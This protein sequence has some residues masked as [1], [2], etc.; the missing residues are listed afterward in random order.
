MSRYYLD[1]LA[2]DP[3]HS[4]QYAR[5]FVNGFESAPED[6]FHIQASSCCKHYVA[7]SMEATR[8]ADG[9]YWNRHNFNANISQQDLVDSYMLPFQICVEQGRVSGLMCSYNAVNNVPSCANKWLLDDVARKEWGFDGK[10]SLNACDCDGTTVHLR[11]V[12]SPCTTGYITSDC[13]AES[14]VVKNHGYADANHAVQDIFGAGTDV[15]CGHFMSNAATAA[16]SGGFITEADIDVRMQNL[17]RVRLRLGHFDPPGPLQAFPLSDVCSKEHVALAMDGLAQS[18]ALIKNLDATVCAAAQC[19]RA[20]YSCTSFFWRWHCLRVLMLG[21]DARVGSAVQIEQ[22]CS[23][24]A[25]RQ[26]VKVNG[27]LLRPA[28]PVRRKLPHFGRRGW[29]VRV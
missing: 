4:G 15:D 11:F 24:W 2:I 27:V 20:R 8:E 25:K 5:F 17:F 26:P 14:D 12:P 29:E 18:A 3:F 21:V 1:C 6:P 9:E 28:N 13:G 23:H 22:H 19:S 16:L 7:N 10:I